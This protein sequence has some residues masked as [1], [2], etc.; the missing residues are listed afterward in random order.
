[1]TG[2]DRSLG[3]PAPADGG[4]GLPAAGLGAPPPAGRPAEAPTGAAGALPRVELPVGGGA[5]RGVG[6]KFGTDAVTGTG[7]LAVPIDLTTGRDGFGPTLLLRYDSGSGNGPFGLGWSLSLPTITRR[8][9]KGLPRYDDA[10]SSDVFVLSSAEDL[11]PF[12]PP[13]RVGAYEVRRYR[14]RI[15]TSFARIERWDR[16]GDPADVHW[17]S[18]SGDNV[19]T[20]YGAGPGSRITDPT[21]PRRIFSWL[22]SQTRDDRGNAVWYEYAADDDPRAASQ[23]YLKRIRYGNATPL[24]DPDGYRPRFAGERTLGDQHWHFQAVFDYGDHGGA[25]PGPLPDRPAPARPDP[26]SSYR[27]GFELR[28]TWLCRRVLMFHSF[29]DEPD[30]GVDCLVAA[31]ELTHSPARDPYAVDRPVYSTLRAVTQAKYRRTGSDILRRALPS[32]QLDY[33]QTVV[34]QQVRTVDPDQLRWLP[35]GIAGPGYR[36]VDLHGEGVPGALTEQGGAW[37]YVPNR[38]GGPNGA[39][40]DV[41][42]G[43]P[44]T[45][46]K[47]P[48]WTLAGGAQLIDLTGDGRLDLVALGGV[49]A[50]HYQHDDADGWQPFRPFR[51]GLGGRDPREPNLRLADLD[52]DGLP[53]VLVTEGDAIV[54]RPGL[55]ADGFGDERRIPVPADERHG[56]RV[57]FTDPSQ[58]VLLADMSGDGLSDLVRVRNGD[59]SYWPN[60]GYG[61]FGPRVTMRNVPRFD[62][63]CHF[64]PARVRLADIDGTGTSD[65]VYLHASGPRL[66]FNQ[67]GNGLSAAHHVTGFPL[68]DDITQVDVVDLLGNGTACLV[69]SSPLPGDAGR[70]MRYLD[71]MG[72][73]PHLLVGIAN[74]L[75]AETR[76]SYRPSTWFYLADRRAGRP[77]ITRSPFPV[78]VVERVESIDHISRQRFTTRFAYHHQYFD[79][80]EREPRGFGMVEQWDTEEFA[81]PTG[82]DRW[83]NTS[84]A[85]YVAPVHTKS[86]FHTGAYLD[87]AHISDYFAAA[88][89][90]RAPGDEPLPDTVLPDGL[91]LGEEREACRSLKGSLLR[92]EIYGLD[93]TDR[94]AHPYTVAEQNFTIRMLQP[95]G[96]NRYAVFLT[97]P[98]EKLTFTYER[99]P[100]DPRIEHA[101]TLNVDDYGNVLDEVAIAYGR[102]RPDPSLLLDADREVQARTLITASHAR[103]TNAVLTED[104]YRVP[105]PA[106][107]SAYE[108]TG[109]RPAAGARFRFEDWS[110][111]DSGQ[112]RRLVDRSRVL[113]R[114]DDLGA[115]AGD[116]LHL[117]SLGVLQSRAI[118]GLNLR[119]VFDEE[120][121]HR[122]LRR[123]GEPLLPDADAVLREGGYLPDADSPG[124]WWLPTGR[125]FLSPAADA[126]AELDHARRHFFRPCRYRDQFHAESEV[127][128]DRYDLLVV[129]ATDPVGNRTT[130]GERLPDHSRDPAAPGT[131]YRL[132][133]PV[134]VTDANGN[135]AAAALDTLGM[136]AA[137]AAMGKRGEQVGDTLEGLDPA[138]LDEPVPD[139]DPASTAAGLLGTATRRICYDIDAYLRTRDTERPRAP[140]VRTILRQTHTSDLEPGEKPVLCN[141]F[142][143]FDGLGRELQHK[144]ESDPDPDDPGTPRWIASGWSELN[145]KGDPVRVFEP[146]FT[147]TH[148]FEFGA[149]HGVSTIRFYDA[150]HRVLATVFPDDTYVKTV[151][152]PWRRATWDRNDTVLDDPRTDPDTAGLTAGYFAGLPGGWRTWY[153]QRAGGDLGPAQQTAAAKAAAHAHT[154][155]AVHADPLGRPFLSRRHNGFTGPGRPE[156]LDTRTERDIQGNVL[157]V[158]DPVGTG[159][160]VVVR[161]EFDLA[162]RVLRRE[163][164][165][166]GTRWT[167]PDA[168]GKPLRRWDTRGHTTRVGYDAARRPVEVVVTGANPRHPERD[169]VVERTSYG[170]ELPDAESRNLRGRVHLRLDQSGS[171]RCEEYDFK[172]N[173]LR[174][175]RRIAAEFREVVDWADGAAAPVLEPAEHEAWTRFD[176]LNRP[177]LLATPGEDGPARSITRYGYNR[178]NLLDRLDVLASEPDSSEWTCVVRSVRYNARSQCLRVERGNGAVT[179][180][181]YDRHTFRLDR[182]V[183]TRDAERLQDL[184]YSYDAAGNIVAIDDQAHATVFFRNRVVSADS[185]FTYDATYRLVE[186]TGRE[187]LSHAGA[188]PRPWNAF[189]RATVPHPGDGAAMARYV[190]RYRYDAAGN[191]LAVEHRSQDAAH[192]GWTRDYAYDQAAG[193]RITTT[194]ADGDQPFTEHYDYDA[195]GNT[196]ALPPLADLAWNHRDQLA[197]SRRQVVAGEEEPAAERTYYVYDASGTRTR[198]VTVLAG[199]AIKNDHVYLGGVEFTRLH[200]GP[201]RGLVRTDLDVTDGKSVLARVQSRNEVDDGSSALLLRH[202]LANH[203]RSTTLELDGAGRVLSYEEYTPFGSTSYQAVRSETEAPKRDRFIGR[204]RDAETGLYYVGARYYS[205]WLCRWISC[206]PAGVR[207]STNLYVYAGND[208]V[209]QLDVNGAW[210]IS[211]KDVAIGAGI[212]ALTVAA[213]V[214]VVASA[215]TAAAPLIAATATTLGVSE[216]TVVTGVV[217]A[218]TAVGAAGTINTANEV[219]TGRT[220]TGRVL[221]DEERSRKLGALPVEAAATIFGVRGISLGGGGGGAVATASEFV[222]VGNGAAALRPPLTSLLP[223]LPAITANA[224]AIAP[225]LASTITPV[226]T[227]ITSGGGGGGGGGGSDEPP[228][229]QDKPAEPPPEQTPAEPPP[230]DPAATPP[231]TLSSEPPAVSSGAPKATLGSS[232]TTNYKKTFFTANPEA[233]GKVVVHHAVEQQAANKLYPGEVSSSELHS[234]ENLRGIPKGEVNNTVHLSQIRKIW[235]EFYRTHPNATQ[236]ELLEQATKIDDQFGACFIPPIRPPVSTGGGQ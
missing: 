110:R 164:M 181:D 225:A 50:G 82:D 80:A 30:V 72:H 104:G 14:P 216:A 141:G 117:L 191:L 196:T 21:D 190:E 89:Y 109:A 137:T 59:V 27:A 230:T 73:K 4:D 188:T 76:V 221:S 2:P 170:D 60:L 75:G 182:V 51:F 86:W 46:P 162:G 35:Q 108:V 24:L 173:P 136:L 70:Q 13:R 186:A 103:V 193:N 150:L 68:T 157:A 201:H 154:P 187:H 78:H 71:L 168:D 231:E 219:A 65:L 218:G 220:A 145:N 204:E 159:G 175:T 171:S 41:V 234:L 81:D 130:V 32:V 101:I 56:P 129:E 126:T 184:R 124:Q 38:S 11:V 25:I 40:H 235:N 156:Y 119:L 172:G 183:T 143:Y 87:R 127:R 107:V 178:S 114:P 202:Q 227:A 67:S 57:V 79:A 49:D 134:L 128:Y 148:E 91:T 206:D 15:E 169:V 34:S 228:P 147:A 111:P 222:P 125:S 33:S 39:G 149:A 116:P 8:T 236:E 131:D 176:A 163:A 88:E 77:W 123:D 133:K 199:G 160:R 97:H 213:V 132:L 142:A 105:Q 212:A 189:D 1:M 23:R 53:D 62:D 140:S 74:N 3:G 122:V 17:R 99:D 55:G 144:T 95:R 165:D 66:Y 28:T 83:A 155:D 115:S 177:V 205:P 208:P 138:T 9:E 61:R 37:F 118:T 102:R 192:P 211:W 214:V 135:R 31:T 233:E 93:G 19:L 210:N 232:T 121:L 58:V 29:P 161:S 92:Q 63:D 7:S 197:M 152:D 158:S 113:Y 174:S 98:R 166:A 167:L 223:S 10:H 217:V 42:F 96:D 54:W 146:F 100:A 90:Y 179:T 106:E 69:W 5:I 44:E 6:E 224:E 198:K 229:Q 22:I 185:G 26:F 200:T 43:P 18:I 180:S 84:A 215:G 48:N 47:R 195:H 94:S 20:V 64:A 45:V 194:T 203:I 139:G 226:M 52:G 112:H 209:N 153:E 16:V 12:G 151:F 120:T 85:S 36:W 207:D